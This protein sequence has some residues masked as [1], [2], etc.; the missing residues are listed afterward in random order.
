MARKHVIPSIF[1]LFTLAADYNALGTDVSGTVI[2]QT[3]TSNNSPYNVIGDVLVAG[4]TIN[5]GVT[6]LFATNYEFQ[7]AGVLKANGTPAAPI[8]FTGT[9]GGWQGIYFNYS[10]PGSRLA[11]C[12]ISNA[13]NSGVRIFN[14]NPLLD[15]CVIYAN[16]SPGNG[17]G[18]S[19]MNINAPADVK[20]MNCL[21]IGNTSVG[22]GGGI[23]AALGTDGSLDIEGSLIS[24][25]I[26]NPSVLADANRGG[27]GVNVSGDA[28]L[29]N[30]VIRNNLCQV[31]TGFS[32]DHAAQGGG[33]YS[34]TGTETLLNCLIL[35]NTASSVGGGHTFAYG[36]GISMGSGTL[37]ATNSVIGGNVA[38]AA[39]SFWGS[40]YNGGGVSISSGA[41]GALVNCTIAYNNPE[42]LYSEN[43]AVPVMN[44]ILYFNANNGTQIVGATNVTYCDVQNG[45]TGVRNISGNPI[46]L[47]TS[48]LIIVPGSPC[49]NA[50]NTNTIYK[51]VGFPPSIGQKF[52]DIGAHGGLGAV[53]SLSITIWPPAEIFFYGGVPGY[54]YAIQ[55]STNLVDWQ[56]VE[57]VQ[58]SH[59]GDVAKFL[60]PGTNTL[61]YR[62]Y[63]LNMAP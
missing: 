45:F 23:Y 47:S 19:I 58:I 8:I 51:N 4:L 10:S 21:V 30:C 11:N 17:G 26:A 6:V 31:G 20:L 9:N 40:T 36:G 63:R 13:I 15:N 28:I 42:G 1:L 27:G 25:N 55:A 53:A 37:L 43:A 59:L 39:A 48:D 46:F 61:P 33:F 52:N 3:W 35:N 2:N 24:N 41:T 22:N 56:T 18:I 34:D 57:A 62:F 44:T 7:V 5:P 16:A 50:G 60:E 32:N 14:S 54:S 12:V 29:R 38:S 49:V